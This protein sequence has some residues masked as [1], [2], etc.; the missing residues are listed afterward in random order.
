MPV[1]WGFTVW[2]FR[3]DS[4]EREKLHAK[5]WTRAR[6]RILSW[7]WGVSS[8]G[9][10]N[11]NKLTA[12]PLRRQRIGLF[13][14]RVHFHGRCGAILLSLRCA[15]P[16]PSRLKSE[17]VALF[18]PRVRRATRGPRSPENCSD[19]VARLPPSLASTECRAVTRTP[20][21]RVTQVK[22]LPSSSSVICHTAG[23]NL[24]WRNWRLTPYG[25]RAMV[26]AA[27]CSSPSGS[28]LASTRYC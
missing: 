18:R 27:G 7:S 16:E 5:P 23:G 4:S 24:G 22:L 19:S 21:L 25:E 8:N 26:Q 13:S 1:R 11:W 15:L 28:T 12:R 20:G 9:A 6:S 14:Q 17:V 3:G 10:E 2:S